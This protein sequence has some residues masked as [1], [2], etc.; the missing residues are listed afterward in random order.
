MKLTFISPAAKGVGISSKHID[1]N[2]SVRALANA[3]GMSYSQAKKIMNTY[4]MEDGKGSYLPTMNSAYVDCGFNEVTV[5]GESYLAKG[6]SNYL[7]LVEFTLNLKYS[8]GCT[9]ASFLKRYPVGTYIVAYNGHV[10]AVIDGKVV[11]NT[12]NP[13]S[14]RVLVAWKK[15]EKS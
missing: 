6:Y 10:L 14:A 15:P 7:K 2:C 4:G 1:T 11:D 12:V 13:S 9:L 3:S 5:F 8:K